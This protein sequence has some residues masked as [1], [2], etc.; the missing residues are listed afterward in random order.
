MAN[1]SWSSSGTFSESLYIFFPFRV[2]SLKITSGD[3]TME[4]RK[5]GLSL[6]RG[7]KLYYKAI[8]IKSK[9]WEEKT[10]VPSQR[11]LGVELI[12]E[13]T[14]SN[15]IWNRI[16]DQTKDKLLNSESY[17][18]YPNCAPKMMMFT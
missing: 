18:H 9:E 15:R 5:K 7:L 6:C 4:Q 1:S 11:L 16:C 3:S 13:P 14:N 17:H 8:E 12:R 10:Q 2:W